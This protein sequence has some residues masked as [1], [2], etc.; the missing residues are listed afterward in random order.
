MKKIK[1]SRSC[2][3]CAMTAL[4]LSLLICQ[5]ASAQTG[6]SNVRGTILDPQDRPVPGVTVTLI[7]TE[8][9]FTRTQT[10]NDD[11]GFAFSSVPP[12]TY[13]VEAEITGFKKAVVADVR[14][15]VNTPV[16]VNVQLEVGSVNETVSVSA[17][18]EAPLNTTDATLGNTFVERQI[19]QLPLEARNVAGLLSLQPGVTFIGNTNDRGETTDWRNGSVN[20]SKSDQS[21]VTLDGVDV[22]DQ[23]NGYAFFSV[24]RVTPDSVQEFRVTTTNPNAEQGRSSGAQVSLITR[25]GTN[26]WHGSLYEFHRNTVTSANSFFNNSTIDSTT[27][28][29]IARPKLLRNLFGGSVAGP[30]VRDRLFMFFNFEG[31]RDA[32][33]QSVVRTVPSESLRQG[34]YTYTRTDGTI[35]QLSPA[36]VAALDPLRIG[37]NPAS[38]ALFQRYPSPNTTRSTTTAGD[39]LNTLGYRFNAPVSLRWNTYTARFDYNLTNDGQHTLFWRGILQNDRETSVPQFPGLDSNVTSLNNSKGM[40]IGYTAVLSPTMTNVFRYGFT[41]QGI[42]TAGA[43]ESLPFVQLSNVSS[44][45]STSRSFRRISPVHNFIDDFSWVRNEH[46]LQFGGNIRLITNSSVNFANS[47][48]YAETRRSR[49]TS[50]TP[51][52]FSGSANRTA[53]QESLVALLGLVTYSNAIYNYDR[54]GRALAPG[55]PVVRDFAAREYEWYVQDSWRVRPNLT[56]SFGV[57]HSLYSP[58]WETNG[59]QVAPSIRLGDWFEQRRELMIAGRPA[60]EA[61]RI[62]FELAGPVNGRRG[63]YDWDLNNFAPR[64]AFAYSPNFRSGILGRL[65]GGEGRMA[66][67]GGYSMV[68]DRVGASLATSFDQNNAFGLS[69]QLEQPLTSVSTAPRYTGLRNLPSTLPRD[70]GTGF[71]AAPPMDAPGRLLAQSNAAIDDTLT[72]PFS[73]QFTFSVARQLPANLTLEVAYVGRLGHNILVIDDVAMPLNLVD[74]Q[75]GVDYFTAINQLIAFPNEAS[76]TPIPYWENIFPGL[77]AP[78]RTATQGAWRAFDNQAPDYVTALEDI[79][80]RCTPACSRFGMNAFFDPQYVNLNTF[81]SI[82]PTSYHGM[83]IVFRKRFNAGTQFDFNYTLSRARDWASR[84]ERNG[85]FVGTSGTTVNAWNPDSRWADADSDMRHN[86]NFNGIAEIPIGRERRFGAGM[87]RVLDAF[88]GGWQLA[89]IW[90][91]TSG[92]PTYVTNGGNYPT[93][94]KWQPPATAIAPVS[95]GRTVFLPGGPNLFSDPAAA[96]AAFTFTAPG[97]VGSRNN[98]RGDGFFTIDASLAKRWTM[99][100]NERHNL[101]LRWEVFNVTNSV[102]FDPWSAS[103]SVGNP[104]TFGRHSAVLTQPRVMQFGLRY[105]F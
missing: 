63:F 21:N 47:F 23:Q 104:A 1:I 83:Q 12:G 74:S 65:T 7:D 18:N 11:G 59:N 51:L 86:L 66:I 15:L 22:N 80:R 32:S 38:V 105:T 30:V 81:R 71:P 103:T 8:R 94:W 6:T 92:I 52:R 29:G 53:E 19:Q 4:L 45:V 36:Q 68:Y 2:V 82:M 72:T 41:R 33:E 3:A 54:T 43:A 96:F 26:E 84:V 70:P 39:G 46:T 99:P 62:T 9:N 13:T 90:R 60:S 40:A 61:P 16:D 49:L 28:Q 58:P 14:A 76:V 77:A 55:E 85:L 78:G 20:G 102:R 67:R 24:L 87:S 27:G 35:G 37:V 93:N 31:R 91:W 75:S 64:L 10:T 50:T 56:L 5:S 44:S 95:G 42:E 79:D 98:I 97:S 57:R 88:I 17:T 34:I 25:S 89:G 73:Q 69:N 48:S 100:W 101:Q